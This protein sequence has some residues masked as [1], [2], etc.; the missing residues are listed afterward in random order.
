MPY[1]FGAAGRA[2]VDDCDAMCQI[3]CILY[4]AA[5]DLTVAVR[6]LGGRSTTQYI[7]LPSRKCGTPENGNISASC[8]PHDP[9]TLCAPWPGLHAED[10]TESASLGTAPD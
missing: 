6:M 9:S 10:S 5:C 3:G 7:M 1:V 2:E 4:P 8:V